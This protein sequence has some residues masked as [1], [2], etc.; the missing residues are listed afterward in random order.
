MT[1]TQYQ[2]EWGIPI[3]PATRFTHPFYPWDKLAEPRVVTTIDADGDEVDETQ[4]ASFFVP[5]E[6]KNPSAT[7]AKVK[8]RFSDR[9]FE[10]RRVIEAV[11]VTEEIVE[12]GV[13]VGT[14][15]VSK[16]MRGVRFWRTK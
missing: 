8:E 14:R 3:A 6:M 12:D 16:P 15:T 5:K 10:W 4:F 1:D 7:I 13:V 11:E 2:I 9:D